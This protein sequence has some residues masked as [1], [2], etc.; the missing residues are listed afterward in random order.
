V[1]CLLPLDASLECDACRS[2]RQPREGWSLSRQQ[3]I[4]V[5][6]TIQKPHRQ[7]RYQL[8]GNDAAMR[9]SNSYG[10]V[11]KEVGHWSTGSQG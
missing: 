6:R 4:N 10:K 2:G 7:Q 9:G 1:G 5:L 11:V 3:D 8:A